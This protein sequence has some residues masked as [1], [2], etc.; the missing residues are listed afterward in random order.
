MQLGL[1][2]FSDL[3]PAGAS[4]LWPKALATFAHT[5]PWNYWEKERVVE[6]LA[7]LE[8]SP[9]RS[10]DAL[11]Y[12]LHRV[13]IAFDALFKP[14]PTFAHEERMSVD[15]SK[16][17]LR[18]ANEFHP[19]YLRRVEHIFSNLLT[20]FWAVLR[21]GSV[22][23]NYD[24]PGAVALVRSKGH[25]ALVSGYDERIRNAIAHGEVIYKGLSIQ[26]G[27]EVAGHDLASSEFLDRFDSIW[28]SSIALAISI[29]VF[30]A[31]HRANLRKS[32]QLVVPTSLMALLI[33]AAVERVGLRVIG[34]VESNPPLV[35]RQLHVVYQ[36]T[37]RS[38]QLA[39]FDSA[40]MAM[41]LIDNG[42]SGYSRFVFNID[43][44]KPVSS[45]VMIYPGR[46][47][48]LLSKDTSVDRIGEIFDDA[49]LWYDESELTTR[50]KSWRIL[51][52]SA[53]QSARREFQGRMQEAGLMYAAGH[54]RIKHA[55][56]ASGGDVPR[57]CVVA[58]LRHPSI[59]DDRALM[60][61]IIHEIIRKVSR[62]M[63]NT[64]TG[65][66][67]NGLPRYGFPKFIWVSLYRCDGTLR[68][69]GSGGW[70]GGNLVAVGERVRGTREQAVFV[71][72]PEEMWKGI[73]F[74]F[75]ID[76]QAAT[77][78]RTQL[79]Q[80]VSD[81]WRKGTESARDSH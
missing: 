16:D 28:C 76:Q 35:G 57:V 70:A 32:G 62:R 4:S 29:I 13:G 12:W 80:V 2:V 40:R 60:K 55:E 75:S 78:A 68:S 50:F 54:Y 72:N 48:A 69:L 8:E 64:D 51:L 27:P 37:F 30:L 65:G 21:K 3:L 10:L 5:P 67:S 36:T 44:G 11:A 34:A 52:K 61:Q 74:R 63:V 58:V 77:E 1:R 71:P 49:R 24:L 81:I 6:S 79:A 38:R 22:Q 73:R 18:L 15:D 47:F 43:Q 17:L 14:S 7:V 42:A 46:L 25:E 66:L 59:A 53:I 20:V 33:G 23:A 56:N 41:H 31:R 9:A 39:L 45:V 26:Y 19:E